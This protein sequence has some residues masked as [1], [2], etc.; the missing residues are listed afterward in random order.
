MSATLEAAIAYTRLGVRV[1]PV[2]HARK[3]PT[4][5]GWQTFRLAESDLPRYFNGAPQNIGALNGA[6]SGDLIDADIDAPEALALAGWLPATG[7]TSGR[8]STPESHRWYRAPGIETTQ[9]KDTD[10]AMLVELRSTG[11]QTLIPPSV[12]PSGEAY[13]WG[14]EGTATRLEAGTLRQ[15]V[16]RVAAGALLARHWPA[17][18]GRHDAALA[19]AGALLRGGWSD[20]EVASFIRDVARVAGD[21]ESQERAAGVRTTARRLA[22]EGQATG[23]PTLA[24]LLPDGA[25]VVDKLR[26]WLGLGRADSASFRLGAD[27]SPAPAAPLVAWPAPLAEAAYHGLAGDVTRTLAPHTEADPAALHLNTLVMFGSAAG[28]GP[29]TLVGDTRHGVNL[30]AA[31][32]G[33]TAKGRKGTSEGGPRALLSRADPLWAARIMGG[34]S[35]GEGLIHNVRDPLTKDEPIKEKGKGAILG[36]ETV[37]T[38][39]GVQDKRLLVTE[40][41]LAATLRVMARDGNTLSPVTRQAWDGENLRILTKNSPETATAPHI[42]ILGHITRAELLR[43]LDAT[44]SANGWANRFLWLCVKRSQ[45]LPEGG[46]A[47]AEELDDLATRLA[48]A[49]AFARICGEL[50][51]DAEARDLWAE[52]YPDLSEGKPGLFGAVTARAEAQ[53]LRLSLVYAVLDQSPAIRA[54]HLLAALAVWDYCEASARYIFGDATG[55][56]LADRILKALRLMGPMTQNEIY[57]HLGRHARAAQTDRAL[58]TLLAARLATSAQEATGGRPRTVWT[59]T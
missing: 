3:G 39:P 18:G 12:H 50:R 22:N 14:R 29:H 38:D 48:E 46:R 27:D 31:L 34:L 28:R 4:L 43:Y 26:E 47:P 17:Q 6:P 10:G 13:A 32:V 7:R 37:V 49:L 15:A 5:D 52:V 45:V 59:A 58:E 35:S 20:D 16:A 53:V 21:E 40:Q 51:R 11:S 25:A 2:P 57:E 19:L 55:D 41:E 42:S 9:Y 36:Y 44:E 8:A 54:E 23:L 33:E 30:F 24:G 56:P 1:V